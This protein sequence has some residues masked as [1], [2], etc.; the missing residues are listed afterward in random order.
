[1]SEQE[2]GL[3]PDASIKVP[4]K[5]TALALVETL[6][7]G[8][9]KL[10]PADG[11]EIV[12]KI[13]GTFKDI[14][15]GHTILSGL[16]MAVDA[17]SFLTTGKGFAGHSPDERTQLIYKWSRGKVFDKVLLAAASP[18]KMAY[19]YDRVVQETL[20]VVPD[21]SAP[22]HT[23]TF[24]WESQVIDSGS[25][26][27]DEEIEAEVIV[28][29]TGAGGAAAA[30]ELASR[31]L[32]VVMIEEGKYYT[33]KDFTGSFREMSMKLYRNAG[34]GFTIGKPPIIMPIGR[35]VGGTTTINSGTCYRTPEEVLAEW[36]D[37]GL[38]GLTVEEMEPYFSQV[39]E[40]IKAQPG[41]KKYIGPIGELISKG[42]RE[43]GFTDLHP[44]TRNA[45][46]CDGKAVCQFGCPNDAKQSTNV[47]YVP[48]ALDRAAVLYTGFDVRKLIM[49]G[50]RVEGVVAKST[51]KATRG[52]KLT[53]RAPVVVVAAGTVLTP[54]LLGKSGIKNPQLGKNLSIHP[55]GGVGAFFDG[56][57]LMNNKTIP[58]GF[59]VG[60]LA[61]EG[62]RL[63]GG[64][65]PFSVYGI[66]N[67]LYGE[68]YIR[69]IEE[70]PSTAFF[71]FMLK[72]DSRGRVL[73][74]PNKFPI[75]HYQINRKDFERFKKAMT[76]ISRIFLK[77]GA[78][79]AFCL[80]GVRRG[81][82]FETDA[83]VD[84]FDARTMKPTQFMISAWHPLGTARMAADK[85]R[86]V[87]DSDHKVFGYEG[88]YIM[89]GSVVPSSLGVN[90][91]VTIMSLATR[92]AKRLADNLID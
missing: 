11:S 29:G 44:L 26:I 1:M 77:A 2:T 7:P 53:V 32:A 48:R 30:Y 87:V 37:E 39:E 72:D 15:R 38:T 49:N 68:E 4:R 58:Q 73:G 88:L 61:A 24:K 33:R 63:E 19:L 76:V 10:P 74:G 54:S 43:L 13:S 9:A 66:S 25:F 64:T 41:E 65:P 46:G 91:Q 57:D 17:M 40:V 6:F 23:E 20:G 18:F 51:D 60:D 84:R 5:Q 12:R 45:E 85:S 22:E 28:I 8:G 42:A 55:A 14:P 92:A 59:G 71:G 67:Q 83:D 81:Q 80:G 36:R 75:L 69:A 21:I 90:P 79:R 34:V 3:L 27:A 47:S 16:L 31:G 89:D 70:Y 62:I 82:V 78:K 52:K 86:G 50:N 56:M 35:S